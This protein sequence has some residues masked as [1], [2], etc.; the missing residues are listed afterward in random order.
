VSIALAA[1]WNSAFAADAAHQISSMSSLYCG[2]AT[3]GWI[4]A[5]WS[6]AKGRHYDLTRLKDKNLFPDGPRMYHGR[7]PGFQLS[8]NDLLLRETAGELKLAPEKYFR[9]G[10]IHRLLNDQGLP[11]IIRLRGPNLRHGLHYI[12]AYRSEL[13]EPVPNKKVIQLYSQDNGLF[14]LGNSGLNTVT[15]ESLSHMFIWGAK[16]VVVNEQ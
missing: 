11:V 13:H 12:V 8:I 7:I 2:P 4:A 6:H 3:A 1:K 15:F 16:R 10:T 5:V 9:I 14:G